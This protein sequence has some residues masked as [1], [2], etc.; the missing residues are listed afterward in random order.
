MLEFLTCEHDYASS[1][2]DW[3]IAEETV[4]MAP[5]PVTE[6]VTKGWTLKNL[7]TNLSPRNRRL[8]GENRLWCSKKHFE[9]IFESLKLF[10][11]SGI[12]CWNSFRTAFKTGAADALNYSPSLNEQPARRP[13]CER[14]AGLV[15]MCVCFY[16]QLSKAL[17][18]ESELRSLRCQIRS[19]ALDSE[20]I[21]KCKIIIKGAF[22]WA[23]NVARH[24]VWKHK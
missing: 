8:K 6:F 2:N 3:G 4:C 20:R 13:V 15:W 19:Q 21:L 18:S 24:S 23:D 10:S 9:L 17:N 14:A 5:N 22:V 7:F 11:V 16:L 12:R 1:Q